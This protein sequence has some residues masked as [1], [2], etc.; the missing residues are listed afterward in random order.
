MAVGRELLALG[1]VA[2]HDPGRL[3]P[4]PDLSWSFPAFRHLADDGQLPVRVH[5]SLRDDGLEQA[6]R[7]RP[8]E[9]RVTRRRPGRSGPGR[10]AEAVRRRLARVAHG[11]AARRHRA[12]ARSPAA[13]GTSPRRLDHGA[14]PADA[15]WWSERRPTASRPR[16]T[17]SATP[18]SGPPSRSWRPTAARVPLMPRLEH[19]QLLDPADR[20]SF[21][22]AGI[23]ASVQPV[24]LGTDAAQA[25][26]LWGA[27]AE[28]S[29]Y[30]WALDRQDRRRPRL[31]DRRAGRVVRSVAGDRPR[32]PARGPALAGRDARLSRRTRR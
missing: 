10:L 29:G 4:D 11:R 24:H 28:R 30:T 20:S 16:S 13:A 26:M 22:A 12:R 9:R 27:R 3:A 21:A 23:A 2:V 32:G 18:R 17:P 8:A 5:A 7:P 6:D 14:G 15:S 25:R 1:V 31:R 19:V